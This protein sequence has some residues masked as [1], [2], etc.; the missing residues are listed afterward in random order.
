MTGTLKFAGRRS[1]SQTA[2]AHTVPEA[3]AGQVCGRRC[4]CVYVCVP[5]QR[6]LLREAALVVLSLA[7]PEETCCGAFESCPESPAPPWLCDLEQS[8]DLCNLLI[9]SVMGRNVLEAGGADGEHLRGEQVQAEVSAECK[10][11]LPRALGLCEN[12]T[13]PLPSDWEFP[14]AGT[15]DKGRRIVWACRQADPAVSQ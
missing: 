9:K 14:G 8:F 1:L 13:S 7:R 3:G 12:C 2:V 15:G 5:E 11:T 4:I 10:L 6:T